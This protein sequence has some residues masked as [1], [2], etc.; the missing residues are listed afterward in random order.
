MASHN[1]KGK[2]GELVAAE[3]LVKKGYSI[4]HR[5]WRCG[6]R[7][8]DI[9]ALADGAEPLVVVEV[10]TRG[11]EEVMHPE[12]AVDPRKIRNLCIA[13]HT[14][15]QRHQLDCG[16]RFDIITVVGD[17][18]HYHVDHVEDAFLPPLGMRL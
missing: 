1:D 3:Y 14:Y 17:S 2:W 10:K 15:V 8:L 6:R 16:V 13:A 5:N 7:D 11:N 12:D 4:C 18:E 9:V